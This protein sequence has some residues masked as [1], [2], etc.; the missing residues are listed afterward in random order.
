MVSRPLSPVWGHA[1]PAFVF[2]AVASAAAQG[3]TVL[4]T[5]GAVVSGSGTATIGKS[6]TT[7]TITQTTSKAII[8]WSTFSIGSGD[9]VVFA[10]PGTSSIT[11]NRVN[12]SGGPSQIN[13]NLTANG[14]VW[15]VNPNSVIF[16]AGASVNVGAL[17]ATTADMTD[18]DFESGNYQFSI[19]SS[20]L[21]AV[22]ENNGTI[23]A[24]NGGSVVLAAAS[25]TNN[26]LVEADFG[27]VQLAAVKTYAVDFNGD[28][29]LSFQV[30]APLDTAPTKGSGG[31]IDGALIT[32][33]GTGTLMAQGGKVLLTSRATSSVLDNVINMNG[34]IEANSVTQGGDGSIVFG[35][36]V[37]IDAGANG[38]A[39]VT[40]T[41]DA[42]G[43]GAG[44]TGGMVAVA[45][46][47]VTLDHGALIDVQGPAGGGTV[48]FGGTTAGAAPLPVS[49][50]D[51][52]TPTAMTAT[53]KT[54]A[55]IEA[56][57]TTAGNGGTIAVW[58]T[59]STTVNGTLSTAG[60]GS[61]SGGAIAL[62]AADP[63]GSTPALNLGSAKIDAP[64]GTVTLTSAGTINQGKGAI[65]AGL[66]TG[67]SVGGTN[68]ASVKNAV[69][70]FGPFTNTVGGTLLFTNSL[71]LTTSGAITSAG[72][73]Q[74]SAGAGSVSLGGMLSGQ[75]IEI[76][77]TKGTGLSA[78]TD[79]AN[80]LNLSDATLALIDTNGLT[81]TLRTLG[82]SDNIT[83]DAVTAHPLTGSV[84][85][86]SAN[87]VTFG[88][89]GSAFSAALTV[90]PRLGSNNA[91]A[92][93]GSVTAVG[94]IAILAGVGD[95]VIANPLTSTAGNVVLETSG[96]I[97]GTATVTADGGNIAL[98]ANGSIGS[99]AHPLN[100]ADTATPL[101]L[102]GAA[103]GGDF[104]VSASDTQ[105]ITVGTPLAM[106]YGFAPLP[107][108]GVSATGTIGIRNPSGG[109]TLV[110]DVNAGGSTILLEADGTGSIS[111]AGG[112][113]V[114]SGTG[115][116]TLSLAAGGSVGSTSQPF[117]VTD[118]TG[119]LTIAGKATSGDFVLSVDDAAGVTV[120]AAGTVPTG[121]ATA[122]GVSGSG[123]VALLAN[124]SGLV[125]DSGVTST[126]GNVFLEATGSI[127]GSATVTADGGNLSLVATGSVGST[128]QPLQLADNV[129]GLTIAGSAASGDFIVSANDA[130]GVTV[131]AQV[132]AP[133][134]FTTLANPGV[135]ASG[136]VGLQNRGGNLIL[137]DIVSA[138]GPNVFLEA[139]ATGGISTTG[140]SIV[141]S[142]DGAGNLS[143]VAAGSVGSATHPL[144]VTDSAAALTIAGTAT[145]GGFIVSADDAN[146]VSVGAQATPPTGFATVAT[147]GISASGDVAIATTAS[148]LVVADAL[149]STAGNVFL[150]AK[151]SITG[152]GTVTAD[153]GN[154]SL[155]ATGSIGSP[156]Q[157]LHVADTVNV[158][159]IAGSAQGS[160]T[161]SADD[162][163]GVDV[164]AQATVPTGFMSL[165]GSGISAKGDV[166]L[167]ASASGL[168][169]TDG[170]TSTSGNVF[171]DAAGGSIGGGGTVAVG[172]G[173][174]SLVASGS[175]GSVAVPL[176]I[177]DTTGGLTIAG[178][179]QNGD[180]IV[181]AD[182]ATGL[183]VGTQATPPT[184]F[185]TLASAGVS[186]SG[187]VG[188]QNRTGNLILADNV[189]AGG[190]NVFLEADATGAISTTGGK[191][192]FTGSS[193][194]LSLVAASGIGTSATPL[195]V[196]GPGSVIYAS[197]TKTGGTFLT[198][199][200]T[201]TLTAGL[202]GTPVPT[203]FTVI[204]PPA[205]TTPPTVPPYL[206]PPPVLPPPGT[207]PNGNGDT[208]DNGGG[209]LNSIQ[210]QAGEEGD[211][212]DAEATDNL[213][214]CVA[215][216][217]QYTPPRKAKAAENALIDG[218][219]YELP[220]NAD[221]GLPKQAGRHGIA[222]PF[223]D[224]SSWGRQGLW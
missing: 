37:A 116:D 55:T 113:V 174:L 84:T 222:A 71:A 96:S 166:A 117:L 156:S 152:S 154:L 215:A 200:L 2:I 92:L 24:A 3:A 46:Q 211:L 149:T 34:K 196:S 75:G 202:Q 65:I 185:T 23:K 168:T 88:S 45:G 53:V 103:L 28:G 190:P 146:G 204:P 60:A 175:V 114:F 76:T 11:L 134:G 98:L 106:V 133:T 176:Q 78:G 128:T 214:D 203:G 26:G 19:P 127:S 223:D 21:A 64:G 94:D 27:V 77:S 13:G 201:G 118:T 104:I 73:L 169:L 129:T 160:V 72:F 120:G 155:V 165:A 119:A 187:T 4:P 110:N 115:A 180:F 207:G 14:Q 107:T 108:A 199:S 130:L 224:F 31:P 9:S 7:E 63:A 132:S 20:N 212:S 121:F 221:C 210:P 140:G 95:L 82:A 141:F 192:S 181:S 158:L 198:S 16:G 85:L 197:L 87:D 101:T 147:A 112:N 86:L 97:S 100:V 62:G 191:V 69:T 162:T 177:A 122:T 126:A 32:N 184:G 102:S 123:T 42:S 143:L 12:G 47:T 18:T 44:T 81:L 80:T 136:T 217:L 189:S 216:P 111:L 51:T 124:A 163:F 74:L 43:S 5:G 125:L 8:N 167:L 67:S 172:G 36:T 208:G 150:D 218:I 93:D 57:A 145:G 205:P 99:A 68:L 209:G 33:T 139:D 48:L 151:G 164:G 38:T 157:A 29:L 179:A 56:D 17:I 135:A 186:A 153:G 49:A 54:G 173:F 220:P 109:L 159:T 79:V 89:G 219:L 22:V 105:G 170:V 35:G 41:I 131:G 25:V 61:G 213:V 194:H 6:G 40:G 91:V 188:V 1:L 178:T 138:G 137:A 144:L 148:G 161:I 70:V 39:N 193:G 66:L 15:L 182:A 52:T 195:T 50:P 10:Q 142:G 171:L 90:R 183:S 58:S 30:T 59:H 83:V 206:Q